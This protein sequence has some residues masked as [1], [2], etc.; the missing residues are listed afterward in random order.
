METARAAGERLV[1]LQSSAEVSRRLVALQHRQLAESRVLDRQVR[2]A[3]HDEVLPR[4]HTIMLELSAKSLADESPEVLESLAEVHHQIADLLHDLPAPGAPEVQRLGLPGALERAV[5]HEFNGAFDRVDWQISAEAD[6]RL[7]NLPPLQG[8]V[9]YFASREAIR[10]AALHA[11]KTDP[12]AQ[13]ELCVS[14][15]WKDG[16]ELTIQDNGSGI[17]AAGQTAD[18]TGHGLAL[19]STLLAVNGGTLEISSEPGRYTCVRLWIP[20]WETGSAG[21][22]A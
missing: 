1:E 18:S 21:W 16:L 10:N 3:L 19:H 8:E 17:E 7:P 20:D 13:L 12:T 14:F 4:L 15:L 5:E 11:R 6:E 2:R 22:Q 9:L